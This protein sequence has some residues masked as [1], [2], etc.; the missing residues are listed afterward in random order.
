MNQTGTFVAKGGF[1][2][3]LAWLLVYAPEWWGLFV[4]PPDDKPMAVIAAAG[5]ITGL[6][7]A[8]WP[9]RPNPNSTPESNPGTGDPA[10]A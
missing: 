9:R 4:V 2:S 3:S 1:A 7:Q 8:F 6:L 5:V 10:D